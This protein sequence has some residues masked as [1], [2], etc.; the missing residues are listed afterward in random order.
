[1]FFLLRQ[2]LQDLSEKNAKKM[3]RNLQMTIFDEEEML[4]WFRTHLSCAWAD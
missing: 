4:G 3:K 2:F 1:M